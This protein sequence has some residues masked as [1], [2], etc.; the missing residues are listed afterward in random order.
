[1][2]FF[3]QRF[4]PS[5]LSMDLDGVFDTQE[6]A[7]A[8]CDGQSKDGYQCWVIQKDSFMV[9]DMNA[10]DTEDRCEECEEVLE[11]DRYGEPRCPSCDA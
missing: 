10:S 5:T 6:S 8:Y 11:V 1:M 3:V 9:V 2:R 4:N 7:Q